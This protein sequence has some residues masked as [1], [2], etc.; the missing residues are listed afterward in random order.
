M[1]S[2]RSS[3]LL[4]VQFVAFPALGY[5]VN[6]L[7]DGPDINPGDDIC[8]T[9]TGTCTFRA[10]IEEANAHAGRD[11]ITFA[12]AGP[13]I[14]SAAFPDIADPVEIDGTLV[15]GYA[16][17]PVV[18]IDGSNTL[19][20]GLRFSSAASDSSLAGLKVSGF[21]AAAV[22]ISS[23]GVTVRNNYFGAIG[24]GNQNGDGLQIL[25][26]N[27]VVG[28]RTGQGN[29]ISGNRRNGVVLA[30]SGHTISANTI[31][32]DPT[33]STSL[34]NGADG[35]YVS[36][37]AQNIVIGD[38]SPDARNIISG[39]V[40]NGINIDGASNVTVAGN[41]IGTDGAGAFRIPNGFPEPEGVAH[42]LAA[43]VA[44]INGVNNR[45]G[46]RAGRN[47]ISGNPAGV[48][49]YRGSA[50]VVDGNYIGVDASG[51]KAI[52]NNY[53]VSVLNDLPFGGAVATVGTATIGNLISGNEYGVKIDNT[54]GL[55]AVRGNTIGLNATGTGVIPNNY[56]VSI[57]YSTNVII[58]GAGP[59]D[60][61]VISGN[62]TGVFVFNAP[63]V[64]ILGN[65]LGLAGDEITTMPNGTGLNLVGCVRCAIGAVEHGN[66]ISGNEGDGVLLT[67]GNGLY[68]FE[69]ST[70][71]GNIIGL[72]KTGDAGRGNQTGVDISGG[73]GAVIRSNVIS[74]N[75][76]DGIVLAVYSENVEIYKNT[77]GLTKDRSSRM[78]NGGSGVLANGFAN[79][80]TTI[81]SEE[82]GGNVIDGNRGSGIKLHG[83][84]SYIA[85]NSIVDNGLL[86]IDASSDG[87]TPNDVRDRDVLTNSPIL[88][89]AE[90][91]GAICRIRGILNTRPGLQIV[92]HFYA[93]E[94]ADP[95]G[96]GEGQSYIG[97]ASVTSDADGNA[98][99]DFVGPPLA[100]GHRVVTATASGPFGT[101]EFSAAVTATA[102][103]PIPTLST[104]LLCALVLALCSIAVART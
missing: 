86:G 53:G 33:R 77:I 52:Y 12:L 55:V 25:G 61:N 31:G 24:G 76:Q 34:P 30:G 79:S 3:L 1:R 101:S 103:A 40:G 95:S 20:I 65:T 45:I 28:G 80:D 88:S 98:S 48:L 92:L 93:S 89:F 41:F 7:G 71:E 8:A 72:T 59:N 57:G 85:A 90:T 64:Q 73:A 14:P 81:G 37:G 2:L 63:D 94:T 17:I 43:G 49:I 39:N 19:A 82:L 54:N 50:N 27:D 44:V 21:T 32:T 29:V 66:V 51:V 96:Y 74:G 42:R 35:I 100:E 99:F 78:G 58:G 84:R 38:D 6:D 15:P 18:A 56:G 9:A 62:T 11:L 104:W 69:R 97:K 102:V 60:G 36:T 87:V 16:G 83:R 23:V 67:G 5:V 22:V 46:T 70:I 91:D 75:T 68:G 26:L 4:V 47:V 10:A 13:I